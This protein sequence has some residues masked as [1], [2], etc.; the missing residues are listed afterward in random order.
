MPTYE[1]IEV[2]PSMAKQW[3]EE[4]N[5]MNRG[6]R[7]HYI[8]ELATEMKEG[9]W[10]LN[11]QGWSFDIEGILV[12]GQ[13]RAAAVVASE[14][15]IM[16]LVVRDLQPGVRSTVDEGKKRTH[17]DDLAMNG[18]K[19]STASAAL[20]RRALVWEANSGL[21]GLAKAK[22]SRST[23]A[24]AWADHAF[25]VSHAVQET[26][27]W[28]KRFEGTAGAL[29]FMYWLLKYKKG[30]NPVTVEKF[31]QIL[32]IG[33]QAPE[34]TVLISLRDQLANRG[35]YEPG[36]GQNGIARQVYWMCK[37]WNA[38]IEGK[39]SVTFAMPRGSGGKLMDPYPSTERA[40]AV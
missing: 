14:T 6:L 31:F 2:T 38:W 22:L 32:A 25:G 26:G 33:S 4:C 19:N 34:D 24:A 10:K 21:A 13:H 17:G 28:K 35:T 27:R 15:T 40:L 36:T 30:Y 37:A 20:H 8:R 3:L 11:G 39:R 7:P 23:L 9:R 29:D 1:E 12:D 16:T 5:A 18:V